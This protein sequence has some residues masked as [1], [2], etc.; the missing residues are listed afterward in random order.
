MSTE[1]HVAP[2]TGFTL[3]MLLPRM[4]PEQRQVYDS[5]SDE[6]RQNLNPDIFGEANRG[7]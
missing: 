3:E 7:C 2:E 1:P 5:M 6:E 4:T